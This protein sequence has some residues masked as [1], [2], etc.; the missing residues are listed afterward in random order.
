MYFWQSRLGGYVNKTTSV[1]RLEAGA[2]R[3]RTLFPA[4]RKPLFG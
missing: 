4:A 1:K 3:E 2:T